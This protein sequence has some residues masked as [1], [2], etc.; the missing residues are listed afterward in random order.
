MVSPP[1]PCGAVPRPPSVVWCPAPPPVVWWLLVVLAC[2]FMYASMKLVLHAVAVYRWWF[3]FAFDVAAVAVA[4]T[5]CCCSMLAEN[6]AEGKARKHT[7]MQGKQHKLQLFLHLF[8]VPADVIDVA[9]M[10]AAVLAIVCC[11]VVVLYE[12][13]RKCIKIIENIK[14]FRGRQGNARNAT[15]L[16]KHVRKC[17]E[18]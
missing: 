2:W 5:V 4:A 7:G 9:T 3:D 12:N 8:V 10:A 1:P 13:A 16:N 15:Q 11:F 17:K 14:R 18:M 6:Y